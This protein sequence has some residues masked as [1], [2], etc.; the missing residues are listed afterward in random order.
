M[1]S[2]DRPRSPNGSNGACLFRVRDPLRQGLRLTCSSLQATVFGP[3]SRHATSC[4]GGIYGCCATGPS[5]IW[6]CL[7]PRTLRC[8]CCHQCCFTPCRYRP[9]GRR[10]K[11]LRS[12]FPATFRLAAMAMTSRSPY[13]PVPPHMPLGL[14]CCLLL[15]SSHIRSVESQTTRPRGRYLSQCRAIDGTLGSRKTVA[16]VL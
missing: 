7:R 14:C 10:G 9:S 15:T 3:V 5:R 16:R 11:K 12:G 6:Q 1:F 2:K 8:K 13:L 4:V